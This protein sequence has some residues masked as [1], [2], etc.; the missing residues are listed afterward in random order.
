[1][2]KLS[3]RNWMAVY[4]LLMEEEKPKLTLLKH[5]ILSLQEELSKRSAKDWTIYRDI[6]VEI[7]L[8]LARSQK[9]LERLK[10]ARPKG[11]ERNLLAYEALKEVR[12]VLKG[13]ARLKET[14]QT[15][16][17]YINQQLNR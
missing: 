15:S 12:T 11:L 6:S 3:K 13:I 17:R 7:K 16:S 9:Q 8:E 10:Q 1:M 5:K 2:M 14:H 4:A